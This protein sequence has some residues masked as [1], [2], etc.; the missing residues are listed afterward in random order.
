MVLLNPMTLNQLE[1]LTDYELALCLFINNVTF[2]L[3][4]PKLELT[5]HELTWLRHDMLVK[6]LMDAFPRLKPEAHPIFVSLME[7][8]GV[9][10]EIKYQQPPAMPVTSSVSVAPPIGSNNVDSGSAA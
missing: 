3:E 9:K 2:P 6:R 4:L 7:K 8:L 10:G 5:A 1:T